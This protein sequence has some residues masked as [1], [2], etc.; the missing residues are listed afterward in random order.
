MPF[1]TG[2]EERMFETKPN[3]IAD[4]NY[5]NADKSATSDNTLAMH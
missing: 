4:E 5:L 3:K 1:K 2:P